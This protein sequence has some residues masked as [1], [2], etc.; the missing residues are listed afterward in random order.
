MKRLYHAL[1]LLALVQLFALLG[2]TG[3]LFGTG[4]LNGERMDRIAAILRGDDGPPAASSQPTTQPQVKPETATSEIARNR[5]QQEMFAMAVERQK[6]EL[7]DMARLAQ[8]I[9]HEVQSRLEEIEAREKQFA[10][11]R[12]RLLAE[13]QG[14]G[15]GR[16][17]EV[18]G[19]IEPKRA[20]DLLM[21]KKDPD[22][23][24]LLMEMDAGRVRK[25]IDA[26]KTGAQME[27]AGRIL[28][29]L[30][31]L[32]HSQTSAEATGARQPVPAGG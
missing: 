8:T 2:F 31:N 19:S 29:Q 5:V 27:W 28:A 10:E 32:N 9:Q 26:C 24:R 20:L 7:A 13:Q 23:T 21:A 4:R 22:A 18:L 25:I 14:D 16:E 6:R 11:E 15:F 3:F 12:K 30:H 1:S 17:L